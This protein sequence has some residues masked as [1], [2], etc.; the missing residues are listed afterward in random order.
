VTSADS[1]SEFKADS[2]KFYLFIDES[3]SSFSF[4]KF[5]SAGDIAFDITMK[6]STGKSIVLLDI[7]I[8]VLK[9]SE[10][11]IMPSGQWQAFKISTTERYVVN[12][13]DIYGELG[14]KLNYS[15]TPQL[16]DYLRSCGAE[17]SAIE[18]LVETAN[19]F[20]VS[21][22]HAP[23]DRYRGVEGRYF[24]YF[25]LSI[26]GN[27]T[28]A[29]GLEILSKAGSVIDLNKIIN[30]QL[31]DPIFLEGDAPLRITLLLKQYVENMPNN[32]LVQI[33][34]KTD[35]GEIFSDG[36]SIQYMTV[37]EDRPRLIK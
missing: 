5:V 32:S 35:R 37:R 7:G 13:P 14:N 6:N 20:F 21:L 36:I 3:T 27:G 30:D 33:Y 25:V 29:Q 31:P 11:A 2:G 15:V 19:Q 17:P 16:I 22:L 23:P 4:D 18:R 24:M 12:M 34:G 10:V 28:S 26:V 9:V 8:R 1:A